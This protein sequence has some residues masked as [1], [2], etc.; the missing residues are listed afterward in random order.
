M[1]FLSIPCEKKDYHYE[2]NEG[3]SFVLLPLYIKDVI[4]FKECKKL[5]SSWPKVFNEHERRDL[6]E[7]QKKL[8]SGRLT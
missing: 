8:K 3:K 6:D 5:E 7:L 2:K 4:R 1:A